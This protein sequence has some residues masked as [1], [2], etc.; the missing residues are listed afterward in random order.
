MA[1]EDLETSMA[2]PEEGDGEARK[3]RLRG[4]VE[5]MARLG[6]RGSADR[7]GEQESSSELETASVLDGNAADLED[8][9]AREPAH[10]GDPTVT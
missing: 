4:G 6:M 2:R 3:A 10:A 1:A 5:A 9:P 7:A 8:G